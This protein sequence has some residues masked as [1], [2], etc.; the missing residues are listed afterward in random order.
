MEEKFR[1]VG[2]HGQKV[3]QPSGA[4]ATSVMGV[5][6][7]HAHTHRI[8]GTMPE[9]WVSGNVHSSQKLGSMV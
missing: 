4:V 3:G 6:Y 7:A 8:T 1:L 2:Q 9:L 5:L